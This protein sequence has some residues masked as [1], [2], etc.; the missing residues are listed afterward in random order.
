MDADSSSKA[1]DWS[2]LSGR[3]G[4]LQD[5]L[6]AGIFFWV[7][8][9]PTGWRYDLVGYGL[10]IMVMEFALIHASGM[11]GITRDPAHPHPVA[12][13][14]ALGM[15]GFYVLLVAGF[16]LSFDDLWVLADAVWLLIAKA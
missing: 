3:I 4:G 13:K 2:R 8:L 16:A 9:D 5:L 14:A 15:L 1:G 7:W 10:L 6:S 11:F 12:G